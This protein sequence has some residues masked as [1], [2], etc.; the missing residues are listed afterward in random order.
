MR[1]QLLRDYLQAEHKDK[2]K[3]ELDLDDWVDFEHPVRLPSW[4]TRA[5]RSSLTVQ[6][7]PQQENGFD[8]GVVRSL[9]LAAIEAHPFAVRL[10]GRRVP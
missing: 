10:S 9:S 2:K 7:I 8:C 5:L 4:S 6:D 3:K 1:A